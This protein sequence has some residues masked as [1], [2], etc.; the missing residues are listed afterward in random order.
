MI[1]GLRGAGVVTPLWFEP[2][3]IRNV[4][5]NGTATA[6]PFSSDTN[7]VYAVHIYTG[8]F[9]PPFDPVTS[10]PAMATSYSNAAAEAASFATPFVVDEYGSSATPKWNGWLT[11]QLNQQNLHQVGSAFWLWKQ[12][13]GKWD[14]WAVVHLD[15]ALRSGTLRAQILS[16]PHVDAVPGALSATSA[17]AEQVS[18]TIDGPGGEATI[19]GGTV[20]GGGPSPT[21]KT[22]RHVTING[23]SVSTSCRTVTFTTSADLSGCLLTFTVPSGHQVVVATP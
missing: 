7:L 21:S 20:V 18:A 12:R 19:W 10:Q 16:Q 14:N 5:D 17:G 13:T 23:R 4:T 15:G 8:V 11:A 22:L 1:T 6:T 9:S 2:S 3:I